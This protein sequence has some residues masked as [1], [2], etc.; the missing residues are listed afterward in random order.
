[1]HKFDLEKKI[2]DRTAELMESNRELEAFSYS[3]SHD[4]R[5]P[6]RSIDGFGQALLESSQEKLDETD[7]EYLR[8]IRAASARMGK[9]I[10]DILD[11]SRLGRAPLEPGWVDLTSMSE[12]I[13]NLLRE[14][15]AVRH[16]LTAVEKGLRIYGDQRLIRVLMEN[17]LGNAW[18]SRR[19]PVMRKSSSEASGKRHSHHRRQGQRR[20]A[21][22]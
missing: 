12:G 5:T 1:M 11:L 10:D 9:P 21:S 2:E 4:L 16:V 19:K 8:R 17:L 20:R 14:A 3:I 15:E 7:R 6:L 22:T 18:N 13:V